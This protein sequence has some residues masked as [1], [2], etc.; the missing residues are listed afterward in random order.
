MRWPTH[1]DNGGRGTGCIREGLKSKCQVR[2]RLKTTLWAFLH[3][4]MH[5]SLHTGREHRSS[6][7]D[8][9]RIFVQDGAHRLGGRL[10][11]KGPFSAQHLVQNAAQRKDVT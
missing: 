1:W 11:L 4:T 8:F 9:W 3:A 5:N 6:L 10:L 2:S 7:R